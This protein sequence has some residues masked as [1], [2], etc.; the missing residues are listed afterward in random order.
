MLDK[1]TIDQL[2]KKVSVQ[3]TYA[4]TTHPNYYEP[5]INGA[6]EELNRRNNNLNIIIDQ[7]Q[8]K[9]EYTEPNGLTW[10]K[11]FYFKQDPNIICHIHDS[12]LQAKEVCLREIVQ[13][14]SYMLDR[15]DDVSLL[16][17][18]KI[19]DTTYELLL[20]IK[21]LKEKFG[22]ILIRYQEEPWRRPEYCH[23][24]K[25]PKDYTW[26]RY[27]KHSFEK[28]GEVQLFTTDILKEN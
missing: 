18:K 21:K 12:V 14:L 8:I 6:I 15:D 26:V 10:D 13:Q 28:I 4:D 23:I 11:N 27:N 9:F 1:K 2:L 3:Y 20:T 24:D 5:F 7:Y 16:Q 17:D 25:D 19:I 22:D